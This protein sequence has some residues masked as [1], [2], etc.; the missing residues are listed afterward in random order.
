MGS[1]SWCYCDTGKIKT[2][3]DGYPKPKRG[4]RLV[5]YSHAHPASVLFPAEFGGKKAQIDIDMY[6]DYG[7]FGRE[8]IYDLVAD[9]NR[10]WAAAHPDH[11]T[12]QEK[13][14]T[15]W[16][17]KR[18]ERW[19]LE[20]PGDTIEEAEQALKSDWPGYHSAP[21]RISEMSWWPFYS[22]LALSRKEVVERWKEVTDPEHRRS[23]EYRS[24]GIF[25]A[26]N[27]KDNA[28]LPYPIKIAKNKDS[29]YEECPPSLGDPYQ[30]FD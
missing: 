7:R 21:R 1:F 3:A 8:D 6:L 13:K 30:G 17:T 25:L 9:W 27:D 16:N 23:I 26:G 11:I 18:R 4:Q 20:H 28:M 15:G 10:E 2:D 12:S 24:I 22:D 14:E 5:G 19:L 29:V